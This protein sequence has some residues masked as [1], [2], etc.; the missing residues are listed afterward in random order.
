[1]TRKAALIVFAKVPIPGR[2]KTRLAEMLDLQDAARLYGAFLQDLLLKYSELPA[3]VRLYLAPVDEP[4]PPGFAPAGVTL[5]QQ[6]GEGLG[7]RMLN[8]FV[9]TFAAGYERAVVVGSDHP[10]LPAAFIELALAELEEPLSIVIGPATDGG[11]YL[12]GMNDLFPLL[13]R[14]MSFSHADVFEQTMER[15]GHLDAGVTVLPEW[16]DV[17]APGDLV[18]LVAELRNNP[19]AAPRTREMLEEIVART[20]ALRELVETEP[21]PR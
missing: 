6:K 3:H 9:E 21:A 13:L 8:A 19:D 20:P 2:V 15:A 18:R 12:L 16:Y 7:E 1:M 11:Y 14:D 17:D 5:L 4:L 10:T